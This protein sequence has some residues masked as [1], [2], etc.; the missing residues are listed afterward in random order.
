MEGREIEKLAQNITVKWR[1]LGCMLSL[2]QHEIDDLHF[3]LNYPNITDKAAR[4]LQLYNNKPDSSREEL[5][6]CLEEIKLP[7]LK[8][9]VM[10]PRHQ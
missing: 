10:N 6:E 4:I 8:E 2:P 3:S 7:N 1:E 9:M 5:G